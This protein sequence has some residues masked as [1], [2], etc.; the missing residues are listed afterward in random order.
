MILE[1]TK[2]Q[3]VFDSVL[4]SQVRDRFD[5]ECAAAGNECREALEAVADLI[6]EEIRRDSERCKLVIEAEGKTLAGAYETMRKTVEERVKPERGKVV[7]ATMTDAEAKKI[8]LDYYGITERAEEPQEETATSGG[9]GI[10]SVYD[11]L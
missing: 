7:T 2:L 4:Y 9:D 5:R 1:R 11:F 8:A 6:G 3:D 10:K